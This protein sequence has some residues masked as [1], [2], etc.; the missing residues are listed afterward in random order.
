MIYRFPCRLIILLILFC[1]SISSFPQAPFS[2]GV[3]LTNWFQGSGAGQI[4][5]TRFTRKD[6]SDIKSLGCDVIRLPINMHEMTSGSPDY[7]VSPLLFNFLDSV[8]S[9]CED[10]KVHLILDN[11]SFD[12]SGSTSPQIET[13][14]L[15][16]WPQVAQHFRNRSEYVLYEILNEPNGMITADWGV[17]QGHVIDAIR[18]VDQ[19][20]TIVVGGSGYNTYT[21]LKN[22]PVYSD[23]NL[24]YTFHFYDP[25]LF[26]HQGATWVS[27]SMAPLSGVPF[28]WCSGCMPPMPASF[29]GSWLESIYN[30]YPSQGNAAYTLSL[31]DNAISFRDMR[32]VNIYCGEF[33][34]YI[35]NSGPADRTIW[36]NAVREYLEANN[37]PW[38]SWDY[39]GGFGLFNKNSNELFE[40]DLNV[41]LLNSLGLNVPPQ[42]PYSLKADSVG[43]WVYS[44]FVGEKIYDA[45]YTSGTI[46]Y[47][48]TD[49][50]NNNNYCL[51]WNGFSQYNAIVLDFQPDKDLSRLVSNGFAIDFMVR[52]NSPGIKFDLRFVDTKSGP[53]D[54]PW[55]MGTTIDENMTIGDLRW[56][57]IHI[58]LSTFNERGAWDYN[59]WYNPEGKFDWK[60]VD[61]L[62]I[63]TEYPVNPVNQIWFDNILVTDLD[64]AI[65]REQDPLAI[66]DIISR[67]PFR[68]K[69][70]PNPSGGLVMISYYL[71]TESNV[72]I[73]IF[74]SEGMKLR[75]LIDESQLPGEKS[76][77]WDGSGEK[78]IPVKKGLYLIQITA[79]G[80]SG[81]G[82]VIKF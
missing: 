70:W 58:P 53:S 57:H 64:T 20:H 76:I 2:R 41:A 30:S 12:P 60:A 82:K 29:Q 66:N 44:D 26:T 43:F 14:L 11:H 49:L 8:A 67:P 51:S 9:W 50:P 55:R 65:V 18:A 62:E 40:H 24:L 1:F 37:I 32:H 61:K 75:T 54:H 69:L 25:F 78:G 72:R 17:I 33:G 63:S 28:P 42:T 45:S 35:P 68:M 7:T 16:I 46:N 81:I 79:P 71:E 21:E 34:V 80:V 38:T 59:T 10:L 22:L 47:Y 6:I 52:T 56:H 27:P 19:V 77:V 48:S 39:K 31:I 13:I 73:S 23:N 5:F 36:Y 15:K 74:S 3:N 4:Q